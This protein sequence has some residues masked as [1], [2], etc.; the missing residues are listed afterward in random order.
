M[1]EFDFLNILLSCPSK[2]GGYDKY[3]AEKKSKLTSTK[4]KDFII[5]LKK[6]G[7]LKEN[8]NLQTAYLTDSAK[9]YLNQIKSF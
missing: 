6:Q 4:C 2:Y 5:S 3:E 1:N 7:L 8:D 9:E